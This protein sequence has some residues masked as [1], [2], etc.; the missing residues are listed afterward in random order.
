MSFEGKMQTVI[1]T[2]LTE[3]FGI[4]HP[5]VCAPMALVTGEALAAAVSHASEDEQE[6]LNHLSLLRIVRVVED[7]GELDEEGLVEPEAPGQ[8]IPA[9]PNGIPG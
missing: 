8:R 5:I 9:K 2:R 7:D 3:R 1:T 6:R 4:Q